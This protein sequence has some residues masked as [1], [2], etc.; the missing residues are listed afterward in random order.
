MKWLIVLV[1]ILVLMSFANLQSPTTAQRSTPVAI[2]EVAPEFRL[3][4]QNGH[5]VTLSD[6]RGKTPVV[7]VFYRGYW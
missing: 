3:A 4:D 1:Q 2:G 7:L 5:T 6:A